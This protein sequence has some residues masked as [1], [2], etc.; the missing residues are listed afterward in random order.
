VRRPSLWHF[1]R[2]LKDEERRICHTVRQARAGIQTSVRRC[3][4]R[5]LEERI[6]RLKRQYTAGTITLK[7]FWDAIRYVTHYDKF[8]A[9]I[10]FQLQGVLLLDPPYRGSALDP[11]TYF[12][13]T[14]LNKVDIWPTQKHLLPL[15][16]GPCQHYFTENNG[17]VNGVSS[18]DFDCLFTDVVL[19]VLRITKLTVKIRFQHCN[20]LNSLNFYH[21]VGS[22]CTV[23]FSYENL[24]RFSRT[25]CNVR[26]YIF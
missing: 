12:R 25:I 2:R 8:A 21:F 16:P 14:Q 19:Y 7:E 9:Y 10:V 22:L 3:K 13:C 17:T 15:C 6:D 23:Q 20:L 5:K 1:L 24:S 18:H 11:S 26:T 4:W